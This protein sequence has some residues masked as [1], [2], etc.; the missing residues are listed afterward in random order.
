MKNI[1]KALIILLWLMLGGANSS[2][3]KKYKVKK[4]VI[5]AG[6]GGH[7]S[8]ALGKFSQEKNVALQVAL[9]LGSLIEKNM[10]DV[11]V[12]YTRTTDKFV[13]LHGRAQ[14]ANKNNADVFISIHCNATHSKTVY[15]TETYTM[16][17]RNSNHNLAVA[18]RENRVILLEDS[19]EENYQGFD[20]NAPESYILFSLYQNAYD[21]SS[22]KLAQ[23]IQHQF[24]NKLGRKCRGVRQAGFLVLW[25]TAAPRVLV[26]IGFITHLQEEKYLNSKS[27]QCHI[28]SGI[29]RALQDYKKDLEINS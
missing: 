27:G 17:L 11:Q 15:G 25:K 5:D 16:G 9:G 23:N 13:T 14:I 4:I 12:I 1:A 10:K 7:D 2:T 26:E 3:A 19:Y 22:V 24:R 18:K 28:A 8:G 6:H 21:D 29:F 20:P